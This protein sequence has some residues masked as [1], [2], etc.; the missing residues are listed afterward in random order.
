MNTVSATPGYFPGPTRTRI[1]SNSFPARE[2]ILGWPIPDSG[3]AETMIKVK[4]RQVKFLTL[5]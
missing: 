3:L 4:I 2:N 5:S 1:R